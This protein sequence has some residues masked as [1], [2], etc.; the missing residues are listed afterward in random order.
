MTAAHMDLSATNIFREALVDATALGFSWVMMRGAATEP[1]IP[2]LI[3]LPIP[4]LALR[5]E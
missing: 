3:P 4:L 1:A 5:D 2:L